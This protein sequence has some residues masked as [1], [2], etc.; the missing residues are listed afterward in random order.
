MWAGDVYKVA[1][2][3]EQH[4]PD[5]TVIPLDTAPT[6]LLLVVG[7]DP[8]STVLTD[9]YDAILAEHVYEDPQRVPD[10][11]LH[12]RHAAEPERVLAHPI[13]AE[14][15]TARST[16]DGPGAGAL[17]SLGELRGT[18]DYRLDPPEPRPWHPPKARPKKKAAAPPPKP[19]RGLLRRR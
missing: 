11:I 18:A 4:R 2:V 8:T 3:L 1:T 19:R 13:W 9:R 14:L 15:L 7:L 16:G 5:L 12:R 17:A 6:G 10:D